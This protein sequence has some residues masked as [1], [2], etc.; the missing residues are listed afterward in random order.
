MGKLEIR[1]IVVGM[2]QTNCYVLYDDE[3]KKAIITDPGDNADYIA[4]CISTLGVS[5]EAILLTH[6]HGDHFKALQEIKDR[7]HVPVYVHKDDAYRLKYQGGFVP[8][9]YKMESDD[10]LLEDG[11]KLEIGGIKIEVIHTPGHTEGG[12]C[13]Y[14][15]DHRV[16][17]SGD[18]LFC[19]SWGRT[20]FPG[21]DEDA[22]FRSIREKLLPLPEDTL[23]L[24]GHE[25]STTIEEERRVHGY[26]GT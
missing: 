18:T 17:L 23:V 8:A 10:V 7:Y 2:I 3:I 20:D 5:V 21:G 6:G 12:V 25:A 24:P 26:S 1:C 13:Y 11:D 9:A 15:P 4:S 16:L 22:L 14:L 19:H